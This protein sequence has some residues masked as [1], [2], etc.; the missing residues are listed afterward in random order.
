[1]SSP[2]D[3]GSIDTRNISGLHHS[4]H[5]VDMGFVKFI[6]FCLFRPPDKFSYGFS[7]AAP[8]AECASGFDAGHLGSLT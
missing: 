5:S 3:F 6:C 7:S 2:F 8:T 1:M 4:L